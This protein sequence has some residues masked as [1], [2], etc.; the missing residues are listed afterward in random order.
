MKRVTWFI[1]LWLLTIPAFAEL[2]INSVEAA[3]WDNLSA[4]QRTEILNSVANQASQNKNHL[5]SIPNV[6][7]QDVNEW[8]MIAENLATALGAAARELGIAVN[9]FVHTPVGFLT[10]AL[11]VWHF[12]G[13]TIIHF[14][15][16]IMVLL[17]TFLLVRWHYNHNATEERIYSSTKTNIFGNP[18]L[19]RVVRDTIDDEWKTTYMIFFAISMIASIIT[20]FTY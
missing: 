6:S 17:V 13:G 10:M 2:Q 16:G 20:I 4:A 5:S 9:E 14:V 15:G 11:V 3:G 18:V 7:V 19:E 1:L 12:L 8:S